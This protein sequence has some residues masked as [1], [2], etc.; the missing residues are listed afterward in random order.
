M[1]GG[2]LPFGRSDVA[3]IQGGVDHE[4]NH[5]RA[6]NKNRFAASRVD[7]IVNAANSSLSD[8]GG[9]LNGT[10]HRAAEPEL[11]AECRR[12]KGCNIGQAK[13]TK[14]L[15]ARDIIHTVEPVSRGHVNSGTE[16]LELCYQRSIELAAA[17]G[18]TTL[19]FPSMLTAIRSNSWRR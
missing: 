18:I 9:G 7:A 15:P 14:E 1:A 8:E 12:L 4:N 17:N 3:P 6:E 19:A 5:S 16:L 13:L 2:N 10:I 11:L